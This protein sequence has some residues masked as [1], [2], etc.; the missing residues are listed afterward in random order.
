MVRNYLEICERS[1]T[2]PTV[3]KED[4]DFEHVVV[5]V[6]EAMEPLDLSWDRNVLVPEDDAL[7]KSLF[8]A[9]RR[10]IV[11]TGVYNISTSRVIELTEREIDEGLQL[12]HRSLVMGE[13]RDAYT[14]LARGIEDQRPPAIWAGNPGCPTPEHLF[15]PIIKSIAKEPLVDLITC[16]SLVD[17]DGFKVRQGEPSEVAAVQRETQYIRNALEQVGR[18]GMGILGAESSITEIGDLA[19]MHPAL[20]RPCDAH[21]VAMFNEL[22]LDRGNLVRAAAS[23]RY[24]IR[25]A[26]LACTMVGGFGGDAPGST[27]LMIASMMAANVIC[28]A[29]YHLCHPIHVN[30]VSTTAPACLWLQSVLCQAFAAHA[31]AIVVCDLWPKSGALTKELL[32]EVAANSIVVTVSGGHLEGVGTVDGTEPNGTGLEVRLMGEVGRAVA[33]QKMTRS[34]A[35]GIVTAL[36]E[37]Y[38]HVFDQPGGNR[39]QPFEA[40][41]DLATLNPVPAWDT[42]YQE[43]KEELV[44]LGVE[45]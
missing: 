12:A 33:R 8:E 29:D 9:A 3:T 32:Y 40:A 7:L 37:K 30:H 34:E 35:N 11:K 18:G 13:G 19:A 43:V 42:M 20:L 28:L 17:V 21:L 6:Q 44:K 41:Y 22:I 16:G 25:N 1:F 24:G 5:G 31:P 4:W 14:L 39:G 36:V 23:Q 10:F 38:Q 2:G 26:S 45:L 27:L 15:L